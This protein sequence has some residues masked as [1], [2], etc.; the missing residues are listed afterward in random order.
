VLSYFW[1]KL[2]SSAKARFSEIS[3]RKI[4]W[5]HMIINSDRV[6]CSILVSAVNKITLKPSIFSRDKPKIDLRMFFQT[7]LKTKDVTDEYQRNWI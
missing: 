1:N 6:Q 4:S 5:D 2:R 7:E 3:H